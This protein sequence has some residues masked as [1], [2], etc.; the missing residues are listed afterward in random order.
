MTLVI[1]LGIGREILGDLPQY[2]TDVAGQFP[3]TNQHDAIFSWAA[4]F[5][6][7]KAFANGGSSLTGLEAISNGVSAFKP[8]AGVNARR[9]LSL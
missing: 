7:L 1:V 8:P 2:A 4:I 5:V 3:V 6:L 9:T